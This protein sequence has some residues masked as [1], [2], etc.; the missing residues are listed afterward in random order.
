MPRTAAIVLLAAAALMLRPPAP[1]AQAPVPP[2]VSPDEAARMAEEMMERIGA[3]IGLDRQVLES[4]SPEERRRLL[5]QAAEGYAERMRQ[6]MEQRL[7]RPV[8]ELDTL[9]EDALM[10]I[11]RGGASG[12]PQA[13]AAPR[14]IPRPRAPAGG[15]PDGATALAVGPDFAAQLSVASPEGREVILVAVDLGVREIVLCE[16]H[17]IPF[18]AGLRLD[19]L[20]PQPSPVLLE[21]IDAG[22]HRVIARY[23]P[24][25][26]AGPAPAAGGAGG[27]GRRTAD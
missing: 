24:V 26:A 1:G 23:R 22:T 15:F 19:R 17:T 13:P 27:A 8:E 2:V 10:G 11:L 21:V 18:A 5:E 9:G 14:R 16:E 20:A 3:I 12:G 7:G 4:A 25:D 6:Q